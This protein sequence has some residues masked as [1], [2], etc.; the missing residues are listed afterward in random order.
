MLFIDI[1]DVG[2]G[3]CIVFE[4]EKN[5][6]FMV[7]C[8]SMNLFLK[9]SSIKFKDYVANFITPRYKDARE[10]SFLLTHFHKDHFCGLKYILK[11]ENNYFDNIY[12]PYP[13]ISSNK[14]VLILE[15]S[16]YAFVFLKKQQTCVNMSATSMFIFD[17]LWKN[18]TAKKVFPLKRDDIFEFS[19]TNFKVLNPFANS[20]PFPADFVADVEYLD[21]LL[22]SSKETYLISEFLN[23]K[24]LFCKEYVNCSNL[25]RECE[26]FRDER[27]QKKIKELNFY[28]A[29][30]NK[31]SKELICIDVA[32]KIIYFFN[33]EKTRMNYSVAQNSS[34][35]VFQNERKN[36]YRLMNILMTGDV[37]DTILKLLENDLFSKYNVI[38]VPHHGT[39]AYWSEI[40]NKIDC[41]HMIISNGTYYAGGKISEKYSKSQAIK[42]CMCNDT[43]EYLTKNGSCCN[44][45]LF[46]DNLKKNGDL[47]SRCK[48]NLGISEKND[49]GIYLIS[50][51]QDRGCYCD[52]NKR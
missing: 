38:K 44:R 15:M 20:F 7:D 52:F 4:G 40:L 16:I 33:N 41:N 35:L 3:E 6:I 36:P 46:C 12:I 1:V 30:L 47:T 19:R 37:T 27:I 45:L 5:D 48:K 50:M 39:N 2:Y 49:C 32:D 8:G 29:E 42:H 14:R 51:N 23:L 11:K 17:F 43:C 21:N 18:S 13:A 22:I 9:N 31:L 34:S 10:K 26:A 24:D 28:A 25:C